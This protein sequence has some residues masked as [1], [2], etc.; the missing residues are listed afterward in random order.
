MSLSRCLGP[1]VGIL[2]WQLC[3]Q[4]PVT[5]AL[6][7]PGDADAGDVGRLICGNFAGSIPFDHP[8][9]AKPCESSRSALGVTEPSSPPLVPGE[10]TDDCL[11]R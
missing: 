3:R 9:N 11:G 6:Q 5:G 7:P 4:I 1:D 10:S 2:G 8:S